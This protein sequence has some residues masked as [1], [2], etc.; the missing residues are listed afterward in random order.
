ML[1]KDKHYPVP[2]HTSHY[3]LQSQTCIPYTLKGIQGK[4]QD[5]AR[6]TLGKLTKRAF[7]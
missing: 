4:D 7:R 2:P 6:C 1:P 3:L 5:E